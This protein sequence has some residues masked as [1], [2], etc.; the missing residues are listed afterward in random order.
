M[1]GEESEE[2]DGP[3]A[4]GAGGFDELCIQLVAFIDDTGKPIID[5]ANGVAEACSA[6]LA[7]V[8]EF[9]CED[10]GEVM[11]GHSGN[12]REAEG[13]GEFSAEDS[14]ESCL[15]ACGGVE[16]HVDVDGVGFGRAE[17][18]AE[19]IDVGEEE[20]FIGAGEGLGG[21]Q[22]LVAGENGFDHEEDEDEAGDDRQEKEKGGVAGGAGM[23]EYS[24]EVGDI[25][26]GAEADGGDE[27]EIDQ[28]EEDHGRSDDGTVKEVH[29]GGTW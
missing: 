23:F 21:V 14:G 1:E 24:G 29:G 6:A 28:R 15:E 9:V 16:V 7:E 2:L 19:G 4:A 27:G 12:E 11:E 3:V 10:G 26:E 18:L 25:P 17:R 20:R 5:V 8:A 13:E 22:D